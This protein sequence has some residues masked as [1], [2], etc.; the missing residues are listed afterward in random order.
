MALVMY[1]LDGTLIDTAGEIAQAV[2]LT[3]QDFGLSAVDEMDVRAWIGNGMGWLMQ[4]VCT[5]KQHETA[6]SWD[7]MM[8]RFSVHYEASAGTTSAL[9]P[10]VLETLNKVKK[11]GIKQAVITNKEK[12]FTD[13]ILNRHGLGQMFD[14]VVCGDSLAVKKPDAGVI[15]HCLEVLQEMP[16]CSLFVGDSEIDIATARNAGIMCWAVPYGYNQ[17]RPIVQA[18]PDCMVEDI[19]GVPDYFRLRGHASNLT[20]AWTLFESG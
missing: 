1:D 15:H 7:A 17:G 13:R 11:A 18:Q 3:M 4:Q 12:L 20:P 2:N 16:A 8:Q 9:Y 19:R 5:A 10:F 6:L 14:L